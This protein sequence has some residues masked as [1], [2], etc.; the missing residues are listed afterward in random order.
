MTQRAARTRVPRRAPMMDVMP[1]VGPEAGTAADI[2]PGAVTVVV[3]LPAADA[4]AATLTLAADCTARHAAGI[5]STLLSGLEQPAPLRIDVAGVERVDTVCL[6]L[7]V[8]LV[9]D[10]QRAGRDVLWDGYSEP[11]ARAAGLLGLSAAL[12]LNAAG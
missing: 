5:K 2:D 10:R 7:L 12:G 3:P 9:R 11:L 8:A 4:G 1:D 6:Q